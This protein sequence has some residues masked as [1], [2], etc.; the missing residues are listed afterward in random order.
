MT[1]GVLGLRQLPYPST[2]YCQSVKNA[3]N[4]SAPG[5]QTKAFRIILIFKN[6]I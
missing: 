4:I 1:I 5:W 6:K 2:L 3:E